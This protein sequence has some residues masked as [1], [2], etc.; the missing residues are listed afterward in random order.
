MKLISSFNPLNSQNGYIDTLGINTN[1][2]LMLYN[3]CIVGMKLTFQDGSTDIMPASWNKDFIIPNVAM[4][5]VKWEVYNQFAADGYPI[6]QCYGVLYEPGEHVQSVN[7]GM[8]RGFTLTGGQLNMGQASELVNNNNPT[9]NTIMS[10]EPSGGNGQTWNADNTGL[11]QIWQIV[12]SIRTF[13][14]RLSPGAGINGLS[15][16]ILGDNNDDTFFAEVA[17][18]LQVDKNFV[19]AGEPT[20][21]P[22]NGVLSVTTNMTIQVSGGW[23]NVSCSSNVINVGLTSGTAIGQFVGI[24]NQGSGGI[25]MNG[26]VRNGANVVINNGQTVLFWW[27]GNTWSH[28]P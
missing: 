24:Y 1:E 10:I 7:A 21:S 8:Q 22:T 3:D 27:N 12:N 4:G 26:T 18:T 9:P 23:M 19:L 5:K 17:G 20:F 13:L 16:V 25:T 14:L 28:T 2:Q 11:L 6:S 15:G